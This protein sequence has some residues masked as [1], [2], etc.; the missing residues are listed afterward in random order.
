MG[1]E[2][3][4]IRGLKELYAYAFPTVMGKIDGK[5]QVKMIIDSGSEMCVMSLDRKKRTKR[6]LMV[7]IQIHWS[8]GS[9]NSTMNKDFWGLLLH[10]SKSGRN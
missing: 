9:V 8:I 5:L 10:V 2:V 4:T 3:G 1:V 6:L 7:D